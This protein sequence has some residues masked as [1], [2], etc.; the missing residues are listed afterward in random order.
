MRD[1]FRISL[2]GAWDFQINSSNVSDATPHGEWRSAIVPMPWQAQFDDPRN[3]SGV[4]WYR[5]H[6]VIDQA[7][8]RSAAENS[9]ILHFGAVDYHATVWLNGELFGAHEG[10]YLPF[11]FEVIN[12][13][14]EGNNELLVKVIDATDDRQRYAEFPFSEVPHGKQS[15]Y[16]PIGGIWAEIPNWDLLTDAAIERAR[17]T[18]AGMLDRDGHHPSIIAWTLI[19]ENWGP[20]FRA[21]CSNCPQGRE[22]MPCQPSSVN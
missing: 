1:D 13:L 18:F 20:H 17:Q 22:R 7:A 10:G 16:G 2:D 3:T 11:E 19:N 8:F 9:A 14:R 21:R 4:A 15:W 5:R 6:F 12:R